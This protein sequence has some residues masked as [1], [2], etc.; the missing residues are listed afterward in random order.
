M[1]INIDK[2]RSI[3][4]DIAGMIEEKKQYLSDLDQAIGDG[5]HGFNMA[6]GFEVV[7]QKLKEAPGADI[8]DVLKTTAMALI[9]N[10]GGASGPL[11]GSLF[12]KA[13]GLAKGL[14]EIDLAGFVPIFKEG[15]L[16]VQARGKAELGDKTMIDVLLPALE[17]LEK[18]SAAGLSGKEAFANAE[19][20]AA[21]CMEKTKDIL[22]K[23]GRASYLGERS[24]GHI[25]PGAT[26]SYLMISIIN[27]ALA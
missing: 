13:A 15:I 6:R 22:A 9:S 23:K 21:S 17:S 5:D 11:Y 14:T 3:I 1:S 19:K 26:S 12:L 8:G 20:I 10:V 18:D 16:G 25:D 7:M 24:I 2:V 4:G 27:K